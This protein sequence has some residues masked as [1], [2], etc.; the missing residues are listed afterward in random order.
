MPI[1]VNIKS[2]IRT[3][4]VVV[5]MLLYGFLVN[6]SAFSRAYFQHSTQQ[7]ILCS[8][9][10]ALHDVPIRLSVVDSETT[11]SPKSDTQDCL[12]GKALSNLSFARRISSYNSFATNLVIGFDRKDIIYPF[13]YFF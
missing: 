11:C 10:Q 1:T 7:T 3:V 13:H 4:S 9:D 12:A 2:S 6:R 5:T 8:L